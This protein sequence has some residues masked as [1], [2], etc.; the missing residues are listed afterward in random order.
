MPTLGI[1]R[2]ACPRQCPTLGIPWGLSGK[3]APDNTHL[4][5]CPES[6]PRTMPTLGIVALS[7]KLAPDN[8]HLGHRKACPGQCPPALSGKLAPDNALL[9][10]C[11]ESLLRTMLTLGIV[12]K[13]CPGQCGHLRHCPESLPRTMP[14]GIVRNACPG[15]CQP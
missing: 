8:A 11:P 5:H 10:H 4:K 6:L 15:Q 13:A 12:Q 9:R 14:T 2:K 7:G 3:L 1:V